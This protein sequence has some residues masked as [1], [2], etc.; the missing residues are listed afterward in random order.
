MP[1]MDSRPPDSALARF[2]PDGILGRALLLSLAVHAALLAVRF[3]PGHFQ[4]TR[5]SDLPLEVVL[6]NARSERIPD[7]PIVLAQANLAG[8]GDQDVAR[9]TTPLPA[10]RDERE[11]ELLKQTRR[12]AQQLEQERQRLMT[13][14]DAQFRLPV[15][16]QR[17][18]AASQNASADETDAQ[19]AIAK[20]EAEIARDQQQYAK[21]PRRGQVTATSARQISYARYY[22]GVRRRIESYGTDHFPSYSGKALYG[23]L[24]IVINI[25]K[26]GRL[27]YIKDGYVVGGAEVRVSSGNAAL[28]SQA[29]AIV[30]AAQ[31]FGKFTAEMRAQYDILEIISTFHFTRSG[32][33]ATFEPQ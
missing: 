22:D 8:S 15:P 10:T 4:S 30:R 29:M 21:R 2:L 13:K 17:S 23:S 18:Q 1:S 25:G 14:R 5:Q 19:M 33:T 7:M 3:S 11:G 16:Q 32:L 28:D 24:V 27:G 20:L 31:P 12:R 9:A 6:V 26:D